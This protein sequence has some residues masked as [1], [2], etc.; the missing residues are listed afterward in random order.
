MAMATTAPSTP[1]YSNPHHVMRRAFTAPPR[2]RTSA[3]TDT[4]DN[5][6]DSTGAET[7]FAHENCRIVSFT[8]RTNPTRRHSSV[9]Q[10]ISDL[11][12][13]PIGTLPW[14]SVTE[15]PVAAGPLRIH[16]L[17]GSVAFLHTGAARTP[18]RPILPKSQ[19]WCVDGESKFVMSVVHNNYYRIELPNTSS[20]EKQKVEEFKIVLAKLLRYEVTPCPFKRGFTVD[21]P[22]PPKTPPQKRPWKPRQQAQPSMPETHRLRGEDLNNTDSE[23]RN[24]QIEHISPGE[25]NASILDPRS[26]RNVA[27]F[28][29]T[30]ADVSSAKGSVVGSGSEATDYVAST[31][32]KLNATEYDDS[33][34]FR[35]PTRLKSLKTGRTITAPPQL[36]LR[37]SPPSNTTMNNPLPVDVGNESSS[38]SSSMDSFHSFHSPISPLPRS[39]S[40]RDPA[41][42]TPNLEDDKLHVRRARNNSRDSSELTVTAKFSGVWSTADFETTEDMRVSSPI[43]PETPTLIS[44]A[45]SQS[46]DAWSEAITPSPLAELR[47]RRPARRRQTLSPLPSPAN[48]HTP[49]SRLS[50]HHLTTAILQKTCSLLLG[51]PV[52][53]VALMLNIASK[54]AHGAYCGAAFGYADSRQRIPCSWDFS[55]V[56][57]DSDGEEWE[58]D[59]FGV[60]LNNLTTSRNM[61]AKE[62][63]SG[64][65]EID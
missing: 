14:A 42:P 27:G 26:S 49:S 7:L 24:H 10:A 33:D 47:N 61:R 38:L 39:P 22:E 19:C 40:Y 37:T 32:K 36:S 31:V 53:L 44:D 45:A 64:S 46:E 34:M 62:M 58:E 3:V 13:A 23:T 20:S 6:I 4:S 41:S 35:T 55:D 17:V 11:Q 60:S 15:R 12:D 59:D 30:S 29:L 54:I 63:S 9:I 56:D 5:T 52:Q 57:D 21:L 65:W 28:A 50:G 48:L 25:G 16:R 1:E 2:P 51:P 8:T 43:L 18:L